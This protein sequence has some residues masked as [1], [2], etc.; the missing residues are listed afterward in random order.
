MKRITSIVAGSLVAILIAGGGF[1]GSA[2][3]QN[4]PGAI[5]TVPFAFTADGYSVAAGTYEVDLLSS[6]FLISIRNVDTGEKQIFTVRPEQQLN[7]ASKG[8]L[9][10]HRCGQRKDLTEFHIPGTNLY[11]AAVSPRRVK[12]SE[13]ESCSPAEIMTV[14]AR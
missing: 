14:A 10:F 13:V 2:T 5:F 7:V 11:S 9:V 6:P 8:L 12:N 1:T 3:A 4:E